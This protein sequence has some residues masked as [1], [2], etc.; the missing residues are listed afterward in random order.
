MR[1]EVSAA[2]REGDA[3]VAAVSLSRAEGE[4]TGLAV[5]DALADRA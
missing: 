2:D 4:W 3:V 1:V 5:G